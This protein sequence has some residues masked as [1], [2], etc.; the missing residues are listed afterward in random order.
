VKLITSN[1]ACEYVCPMKMSGTLEYTHCDG[2]SCM[3][4][5]EKEGG[6]GYCGLVGD[7]DPLLGARV[8]PSGA[9]FR[10]GEG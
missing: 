10:R 6:R 5:R 9:L 1:H 2:D 8:Y 7:P 4:W 3:A